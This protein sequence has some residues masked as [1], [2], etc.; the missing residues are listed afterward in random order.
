MRSQSYSTLVVLT[1]LSCLFLPSCTVYRSPERKDFESEYN[2]FKVQNLQMSSCS[3]KSVIL[4]ASAS[5]LVH[6][7]AK[8]Y[9]I[10]EH[11][12]DQVSVFESNDFKGEYC[13]YEYIKSNT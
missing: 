7:D 11:I 8:N 3:D 2:G 13:V 9:S 5:K 6:I 4:N 1:L 10:W 12:I